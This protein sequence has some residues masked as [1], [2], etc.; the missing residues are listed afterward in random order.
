MPKLTIDGNEYEGQPGQTVIQ[1]ALEHGIDIPHFCWHPALTVA[2]N[3]RMCLVEVEKM[4]EAANCVRH[5]D[6]R[7]HGRENALGASRRRAA[8]TSWNSCSS[9]IRSIARSAMKPANASC[10]IMPSIIRAAF[11]VLSKKKFTK[12][13]AWRLARKYCSM[14]NAVFPAH[15]AFDLRMRSRS[16]RFSLSSIAAIM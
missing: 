16:S 15:D 12:R 11:L 10:K 3:C 6:R 1:V 4:R 2:G 14:P 8:R 7:G 5:A 13:S 9:I